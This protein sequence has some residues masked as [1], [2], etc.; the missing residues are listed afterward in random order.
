MTALLSCPQ[1]FDVAE[2]VVEASD[3]EIDL[4]FI[5]WDYFPDGFPN[6]MIHY[7]ESLEGHD[8]AFLASFDSP[9]DI[10]TQLGVIYALPRYLIRSLRI[11]LPYFPTG[12]MERVEVEGQIATAMTLARM[13]SGT[14]LT[15]SGPAEI[16]IYD[17][18]AL[19]ERFY[20]SDQVIPSLKSGIPLFKKRLIQ[21]PHSNVAI[22]FPDEGAWKRF[23]RMF[24]EFP[25]IICYKIKNGAERVV[26]IVEGDPSGMDVWIVDD[27][28]HTGGTLHACKDTLLAN[29]ARTVS[30]YATHGVF[31]NES[32][33]TFVGS[34][35]SHIWITDSCPLTA[36][37]V[38]GQAPFEVLSLAPSI[39][40]IITRD[41]VASSRNTLVQGYSG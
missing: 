7:A 8:A 41:S 26:T 28:V 17:I 9:G 6:I 1:M 14:P 24:P 18:H 21:A 4:N 40:Q 39:A 31:P 30:A 12:T 38:I 36:K 34:G 11:I 19:Q 13:I 16:V 32:W 37:V 22:A 33:R 29:G 27:L 3:G 23:G 25:H 10:F 15:K 35:F 5:D 2:Q 20:F